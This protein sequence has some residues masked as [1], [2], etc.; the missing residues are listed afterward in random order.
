MFQEPQLEFI[1]SLL[2]FILGL[3]FG[4]F[5][6]V[7][8][9]RLPQRKSIVKPPSHCPRCLH[10]IAFYENVPLLSYLLLRGKCRYCGAKISLRYPLVEAGT[11]ALFLAAW[12]KFGPSMEFVFY[13]VL[14]F[15]LIVHA[16]I[17]YYHFLLLDSM[18]IAGAVF[19]LAAL[20]LIPSLSLVYGLF[21]AVFGGGL[22]LLV[23]FLGLLIF[24]K[25]GMGLGDVKTAAMLGLY[26][27][28]IPIIY[29]LLGASI[30]GLAWGLV[31]LLT[32]K[33]RMV[34]FGTLMAI[35]AVIMILAGW[36]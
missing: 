17:D 28:P 30:V 19:G 1:W 13:T 20:A 32:G 33:G 29:M 3:I 15:I 5:A 11:A 24:R 21:G 9:H 10:T 36:A 4:S 25:R 23:Y 8:I 34:Q 26:L 6:N 12:L 31:R 22:L 35:A 7:L 2:V 18:N 16:F 27:G 14:F